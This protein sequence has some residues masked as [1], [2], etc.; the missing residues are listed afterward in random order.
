[1]TDGDPQPD[2][3]I[4]VVAEC[5]ALVPPFQPPRA[6]VRHDR[7]FQQR[8]AGT[9][10]SV[11]TFARSPYQSACCSWPSHLEV[12]PCVTEYPAVPGPAETADPDTVGPFTRRN[13]PNGAGYVIAALTALSVGSILVTIVLGGVTSVSDF[14]TGVGIILAVGFIAM[15]TIGMPLTLLAHVVLRRVRQQSVHIVAFGVVGLLTGYLFGRWLFSPPYGLPL[16]AV[17]AVGVSAA[18]GRAAVNHRPR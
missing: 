6:L 5:S 10:T 3:R 2:S 11:R 17:L 13:T 8:S 7:S 18:A 15:L 16:P 14:V 1:M 9:R 4:E 12:G